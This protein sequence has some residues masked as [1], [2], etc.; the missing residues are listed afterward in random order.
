MGVV[1]DHCKGCCVLYTGIPF[2]CAGCAVFSAALPT[3]AL[4]AD[5]SK[6]R[7]LFK[8]LTMNDSHLESYLTQQGYRNLRKIPGRGWCGI[9]AMLFS[10]G[11]F[12]GLNES[13]RKGRYDYKN[14]ADAKAAVNEWSGEDHPPGPWFT[15]YGDGGQFD[16]PKTLQ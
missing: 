5:S 1:A 2:I 15:H 16:N 4:A 13:G 3:K 10:W 12:Y 6:G 9:E 7:G 14:Y 11:L 8:L